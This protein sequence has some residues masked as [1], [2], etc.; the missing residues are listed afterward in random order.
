LNLQ[1]FNLSTDNT[2]RNGG[3]IMSTFNGKTTTTILLFLAVLLAA[4][5]QPTL[6]PGPTVDLSSKPTSVPTTAPKPADTPVVSPVEPP[7]PEPVV[8]KVQPGD[9]LAVIAAR[10]NVTVEEI[11]A[12]NGLDDP[13]V[14]SVGQEL[15]IPA[16]GEPAASVVQELPTPAAATPGASGWAYRA[17]MLVMFGF[18]ALDCTQEGIN[19]GSEEEGIPLGHLVRDL[20]TAYAQG[21]DLDALAEEKGV[22]YLWSNVFAFGREIA[23]KPIGELTAN[24]CA[25]AEQWKV[26]DG[27]DLSPLTK[28]SVVNIASL[29]RETATGYERRFLVVW[30]EG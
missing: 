19:Y 20:V 14:I 13:N 27:L 22:R 5:S 6:E 26:F 3:Y 1:T 11:M 17:D 16:E 18:E 24:A 30:R 9:T 23:D 4:C 25:Y 8:Y 7:I 2:Q 15:I 21:A 28:A 12:A 10:Y 29:H